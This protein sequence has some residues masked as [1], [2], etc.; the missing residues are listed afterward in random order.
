MKSLRKLSH[1]RRLM[2][3]MPSRVVKDPPRRAGRPRVQMVAKR[4]LTALERRR[5]AILG[6]ALRYSGRWG[7]VCRA[8][9]SVGRRSKTPIRSFTPRRRSV[10]R[11]CVTQIGAGLARLIQNAMRPVPAPPTRA[12]QGNLA[13]FRRNSQNDGSSSTATVPSEKARLSPSRTDPSADRVMRSCASAGSS[14]GLRAMGRRGRRRRRR[15]G[16]VSNTSAPP[17]VRKRGRAAR[18]PPHRI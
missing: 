13:A 15:Y 8:T 17:V 2:G 12:A 11:M 14:G 18:G 7:T 16:G 5:S 9:Q 10:E 1:R 6:S 4:T 3:A